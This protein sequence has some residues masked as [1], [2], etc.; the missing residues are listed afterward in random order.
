MKTRYKFILF[1]ALAAAVALV[2]YLVRKALSFWH[3]VPTGE[4]KE[5]VYAIRAGG[6]VNMYLCSNG[7]QAIAIDTTIGSNE[8]KRGLKQLGIDSGIVTDV[9]LTHSDGDHAGGVSLFQAQGATVYMGS[10]EEQLAKGITPRHGDDTNDPVEPPYTL[11][12]DGAIIHAGPFKVEAIATPGHTTG[13]MAYLVNDHLLFAG[14]ILSLVEG[15]VQPF[16]TFINMDT[17]TAHKSIKRLAELEGIT[18]MCTGH[19]GCT[20]DF[21]DAMRAWRGSPS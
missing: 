18:L 16:P 13:H 1:A 8:V 14:D 7:E 20:E 10:D 4:V 3:P 6:M 11:L 5:G 12:D 21:E 15:H 9:F 2:V 17:E 19:S